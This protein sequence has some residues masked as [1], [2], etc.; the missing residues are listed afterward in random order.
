[1][2]GH[3]LQIENKAMVTMNQVWLILG[4]RKLRVDFKIMLLGAGFGVHVKCGFGVNKNA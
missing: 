3:I 2:V 1:M 4:D